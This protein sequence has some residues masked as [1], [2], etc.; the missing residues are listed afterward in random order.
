MLVVPIPLLE[1]KVLLMR[2][3]KPFPISLPA[4]CMGRTD[5]FSP[6][7][8]FRWPP[9]PG[10]NDHPFFSSHRLNLALLMFKDITEVLRQAC[11]ATRP[12]QLDRLSAGLILLE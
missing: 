1:S 7:R 10:S 12:S 6:N 3:S 2:C 11:V 9:L 5:T 4:P 8:T